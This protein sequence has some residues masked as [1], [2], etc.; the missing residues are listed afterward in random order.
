MA[1]LMDLLQ[2]QLSD[3]LIE[4]LSQQLGGADKQ[5]TQV[6]AQG[7]ISTLLAALNKN[8]QSPDGAEALANALDNDHDGGI[9]D[10]LGA[11]LGGAQAAPE[12]TMARAL[13]GAGI[14]K[15]VLGTKQSSAIDMIAQMSGLGGDK[16]GN[17]MT[18][19]APMVMA[20]LGR[21]KR[22][23]GL[24]A[25]G[26][27]RFLMSSVQSASAKQQEMGLIGKLL[28]QDGD[29]SIMDDLAGMGMKM[30]G[31]FLRK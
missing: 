21:Q 6:A 24:D 10:N 20:M 29:G 27:A 28:D 16:A 15:H 8:A 17:L 2:G 22:Q 18:T 13:N 4:Q 31:R 11:L 3:G 12:P 7:A 1:N 14:L 5:A 25:S 30:F 9:L 19:L 26:I 23:Q